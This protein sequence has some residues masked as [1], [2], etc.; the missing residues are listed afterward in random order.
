MTKAEDVTRKIDTLVGEIRN[1]KCLTL[2]QAFVGI[3]V[4]CTLCLGAYG[5]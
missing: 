4:V 2:P 1:I 3:F 5:I